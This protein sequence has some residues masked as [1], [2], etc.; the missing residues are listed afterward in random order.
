MKGRKEISA[1]QVYDYLLATPDKTRAPTQQEIASALDCN[2]YQVELGIYDLE[3]TGRIEVIRRGTGTK[4]GYLLLADDIQVGGGRLEQ[5]NNK[6]GDGPG[7][8]QRRR[9]LALATGAPVD[10]VKLGNE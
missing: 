10:R 9:A 3:R 4:R 6:K 2:T 7:E 1:E 8:E 5:P